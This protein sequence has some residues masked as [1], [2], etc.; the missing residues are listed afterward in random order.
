LEVRIPHLRPP[1]GQPSLGPCWRP[2]A[3]M[4]DPSVRI[5]GWSAELRGALRS[6]V[7]NRQW[8]QVRKHGAGLVDDA[9]CCLCR[10]QGYSLIRS[11]EV[12]VGSLLHRSLECQCHTDLRRCYAPEDVTACNGDAQNGS[13]RYLWL[14][15]ALQ[16]TNAYQVP[17]PSKE[18]SFLWVAR[19]EGGLLQPAWKVYTDG[20]LLDG[21]TPLLRR[22][23][24]AF[25]AIDAE[26]S[27][28]ASAHG[29][30]PAWITT[31]FGAETWAVLQA[32]SHAEQQ[33]VLRIDCKAVVDLLILGSSRAVRPS[34]LTAKAW[35]QIFAAAGDA[36]PLDVAWMPAHTSLADIGRKRLSNGEMLTGIDRRAND[37][38]DHLAK[39][40]V[41]EHRVPPAVRK[42]VQ[43]Q[44]KQVT[45][46]AWWVARVTVAANSWGSQ[47]LRDSDSAPRRGGRAQKRCKRS[48]RKQEEIP[49][50][51]GGHD[52]LCLRDRLSKP[53]Q[54]R[55]CHRSSAKRSVLSCSKCPGSAVL[56]WARAADAAAA[57]GTSTGGGHHLLLTGTITWCWKCG[58]YAC[59][60]ACNLV[61]P[62]TG[63]IRGFAA[64]ARQ[65]LLLGLHPS[66][67]V[68]LGADTVPEPGWSLPD[69][70]T[71]AV[72]L[73]ET[74]ATS[75]HEVPYLGATGD[76]SRGAAVLKTARMVALRA[77]VVA[78]EALAKRTLG[79][80]PADA[81][82]PVAMRRRLWG[83]QPPETPCA[84]WTASHE[85]GLRPDRHAQGQAA[86][87]GDS[88]QLSSV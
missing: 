18:A 34:R 48:T 28:R 13:S 17:P 88:S 53:W 21:P 30:P 50:A 75:P 54:C 27:V 56:T 19:P 66:S 3:R 2:L 82:I 26:G 87:T 84:A 49:F 35:A 16:S 37:I 58:A 40:A 79:A 1:P 71:R 11:G 63:R 65:R 47:A 44:E 51:L 42:I 32:V 20:S 83:K 60:K 43:D 81:G 68:P 69:G 7:T 55:V 45:E 14:T 86:T 46:M 12:P 36:P 6:A 61:K 73:A 24:W 41:S 64:T 52:V 85:T 33:A 74:S 57:S 39:A 10:G 62:C 8:P 25:V 38:A 80:T 9:A 77:R 78:R 4:L 29:V 76:V 59:V 31:I 5:T 70:F 22:T 15:R 67:R 72:E 23:G